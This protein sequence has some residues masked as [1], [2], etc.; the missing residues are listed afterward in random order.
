MAA[1]ERDVDM[2]ELAEAALI[3]YLDNRLSAPYCYGDANVEQHDLLEFVLENGSSDDRNWITGG[4]KI[5]VE[6]IRSRSRQ[7]RNKQ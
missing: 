5:L 1:A 6:A 2:G 7:R 4:L 3:A